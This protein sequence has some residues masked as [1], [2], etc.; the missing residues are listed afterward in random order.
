M[1]G[2]AQM[3]TLLGREVCSAHPSAHYVT[4]GTLLTLFVPQLPS[5]P[6]TGHILL[7]NI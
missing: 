3:L 5:L 4:L 2:L 7:L 1:W 6:S